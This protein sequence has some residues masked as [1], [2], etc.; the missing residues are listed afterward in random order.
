MHAARAIAGGVVV[1]PI[2]SRRVCARG[3]RLLAVAGTLVL[4]SF[5]PG[6]TRT[7]AVDS[8]AEFAE[9]IATA[10]PGDRIAIAAG[11]YADWVL[12]VPVE[13]TG[14]A[15]HMISITPETPG[16]VTFTGSSRIDIHASHIELA[17]FTFEETGAPSVEIFGSHVRATGLEFQA[18]GNKRKTHAP[19][20]IIHEAAT[21]NEV[22]HCLFV[23]SN[24]TSIQIRMPIDDH[25]GLPMRNRIHDNEFR[26]IKRYSKNGQE[27][28]QVGQGPG[29]RY[30]LETSVEHNLFVRANGDDE[31]VSVKTS[32][33]KIRYNVAMD[34]AGGLSLRGGGQN[35]VE[36]NVLLRTK[37]GVV[38]TGD[39]QTVINNFIDQP[40][41]EGIL[42]AVGSKRYR[43]ATNAVIAHNTVIRAGTPISFV[44]RDPVVMAAPVDNKI[45]NNIF[46][47]RRSD[48]EVI[49][50]NRHGPLDSYLTTNRVE[51]NL[52]WWED[53]GRARA[54]SP[55]YQSGGNIVADP[56]LD[57]R[58]PRVPRLK[59]TS[60]ARRCGLPGFAT[61]DMTGAQRGEAAAPDIG[62][63]QTPVR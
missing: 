12:T 47:A 50:A 25:A 57:L 49:S 46:V 32:G 6:H 35:L 26:D 11:R 24:S 63:L 39:G 37:R 55:L 23:A 22:D 52:F 58:D 36:G 5:N 29:N 9:A 7:H 51:G 4:A 59:A 45:V 41:Q 16:S 61:A 13:A 30:V 8:P 62:A 19:I 28:I 33:N 44:L 18:A 42:V 43:A 31:L 21:D 34:S 48:Q 3:A 17:N 27:P 15:G 10:Q 20:F 60:P 14:S 40:A 2:A 38:V 56:Q 54:M 1:K 53:G